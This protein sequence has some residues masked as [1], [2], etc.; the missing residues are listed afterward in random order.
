[1]RIARRS[2]AKL[3]LGG[4]AAAIVHAPARAARELQILAREGYADDAW[5]KAFQAQTGATVTVSTVGSTEELLAR[6]VGAD[7]PGYDVLTFDTA[8]FSR[9]LEAK[10]FQ[11]L[12]PARLKNRTHLLPAF[13]QVVAVMADGKSYGVPFAW[14]ARPLIYDEPA[15]PDGPPASW[16]V[17]WDSRY[18]QQ[19][20]VRDD[21]DDNITNAA[22]MLGYKDPF[23]LTEDQL[24]TIRT[25]L[26]EQRKLLLTTYSGLD[27][28][29]GIFA[30]GGVKLMPAMDETQAGLL[31]DKGV[32][33][34]AAV[35]KEGA[36]GWLDCWAVGAG[37][38]DSDL[39]Y[40]WLNFMLRREVGA[41]LTQARGCGNTTEPAANAKAGR[42][43]ADRLAW[44]QTPSDLDKRRALWDEVKAA[45]A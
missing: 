32:K 33:A 31:R 5:A 17:L 19:M 41:R 8:S 15:F 45:P 27:D 4:A 6:A 21:G 38:G 14:G 36:A 25:R 10:L 18:A 2:F 13:R 11:P 22:I 1:M 30:R 34:A 40:R 7:N 3:A 20:I 28:G 37:A 29:V 35:P 24:A 44:L 26:I 43:Y 12:D 42:T 23:V 16:T 9:W 39:A